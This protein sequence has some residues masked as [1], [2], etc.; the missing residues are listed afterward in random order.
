VAFVD[1]GNLAPTWQDAE[2]EQT[3]IAPG[4]GLRFY[5]PIGAVF[6]D[7]GYNLIRLDGDPVGA[8]Q[9][10]FGFTF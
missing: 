1:L 5:T 3:R 7:Y 9:F 8:V 10:G 4:L 6:V 2:I